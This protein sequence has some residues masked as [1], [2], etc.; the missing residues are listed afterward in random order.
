MEVVKKLS[1]KGADIEV[2]VEEA[3]A[4]REYHRQKELDSKFDLYKELNDS[5]SYIVMDDWL[6]RNIYSRKLETIGK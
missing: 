2:F 5:S 4:L 3:K 6:P 1:R